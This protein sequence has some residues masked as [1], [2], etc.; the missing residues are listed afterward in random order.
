MNETKPHWIRNTALFLGGQTV[1]LF[2]SMLVQYAVMW[3][4]TLET[5]SGV[6]LALSAIVGF[7]PQAI[8]SLFGGVW[9][10]R[11]NR[12]LLIITA[13][14]SIALSTLIL[15]LLMLSSMDALW[16]IL[17]VLMIRS[18]GAGI[19]M[20]AVSALIPQLVPT[21]K[22]MRVNGF[23]A[24]LQSGL[25][26][27]APAVA[28]ALYAATELTSILFIDVVTAVIGVGFLLL[29]PVATIRSASTSTGY[30]SDLRDG[31]RYVSS[32]P[33]VLWIIA[34][35]AII[36]VLSVAPS[37]LTPLMVV[38]SFGDEVWMLA[39]LELAFSI[40]M[41]LGGAALAVWGGFRNRVAMIVLASGLFGVLAIGMGL[42]TN[43]WVFFAL[44]FV[45][46]L[47]V[48]LFSTPTM[49]ILQERV[50]PEYQ[51]RVF[52]F[53]SIAMSLGMPVGMALFGPW[54]DAVSVELLLIIS[55]ALVIVVLALATATK[56]GRAAWR[57]GNRPDEGNAGSEERAN[58]SE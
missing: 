53:L 55:G 41:V 18:L 31:L 52:G 42:T 58:P 38:R 20:P 27:V 4:L 6:I 16:L 37:Y 17:A 39:V 48:P 45:V 46:G 25:A 26:I 23:Y 30:F 50:E 8:M 36:F 47:A 22:L 32:H 40:G 13:D 15:A 49:T 54:A 51:G 7:G 29:I 1:S 10:D 5:K 35:F 28:A 12:K 3:H 21:D 34:L 11:H 24:S 9:A 43:L 19:Q 2:G 14:L 57:D 56:T 44:M 33:I